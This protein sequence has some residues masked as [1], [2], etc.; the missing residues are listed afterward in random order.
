[1]ISP[2]FPSLMR[3]YIKFYY[4]FYSGGGGGGGEEEQQTTLYT[5]FSQSDIIASHR[6]YIT[7]VPSDGKLMRRR[8]LPSGV[9]G[10]DKIYL[11]F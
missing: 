4:C 5:S 7:V 11:P 2:L 3:E 8:I 6:H 10:N 1:M 9:M